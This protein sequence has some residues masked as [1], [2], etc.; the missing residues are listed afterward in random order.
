MALELAIKSDMTV[1]TPF[2][3]NTADT[4]FE[5]ER[6]QVQDRIGAL[7]S[8]ELLTAILGLTR[9]VSTEAETYQFWLNYVRPYV[10]HAIFVR[11]IETHG[12]NV[13]PQGLTTFRDGQ[14]TAQAVSPSERS[15]LIRKWKSNRELYLT[16]MLW[17]FEQ[18]QGVFDSVSYEINEDK[19][20][21]GAR[22][23]PAM[24]M[25]GGVNK[26]LPFNRKF[27]L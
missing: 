11:L 10:V 17:Q 3:L 23:T 5:L 7:I 27:R 15:Q 19:Y 12:Y 8:D 18:V 13:T 24:T 20:D 2:S 1:W 6:R 22:K 16:K 14:N 21:V 26:D 25:I 4:V 9:D